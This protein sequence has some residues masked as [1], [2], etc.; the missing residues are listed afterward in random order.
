MTKRKWYFGLVVMLCC[1][2]LAGSAFANP[3][4]WMSTT[5]A[6][7]SLYAGKIYT[8]TDAVSNLNNDLP[9]S[10]SNIPPDFTFSAPSGSSWDL[11]GWWEFAV[12]GSTANTPG[13]N[14]NE[15]FAGGTWHFE[16]TWDGSVN[17]LAGGVHTM[18][19]A[20]FQQNATWANMYA[21]W[22]ENNPNMYTFFSLY[23]DPSSGGASTPGN[24]PVGVFAF[25]GDS[26]FANFGDVSGIM[27]QTQWY[28]N[29]G[30]LTTGANLGGRGVASASAVP[31]PATMLLLGLGLVGIAGIRRKF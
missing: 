3:T 19:T 13:S 30:A 22:F 17:D 26:D 11:A 1:L 29:A 27:S 31:E 15:V 8:G 23:V 4:Y 6:P 5:Q 18:P 10:V 21:Q 12:T 7:H 14:W 25:V 28:V 2:L 16:I 24:P 20:F 9:P